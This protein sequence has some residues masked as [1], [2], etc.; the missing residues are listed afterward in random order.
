MKQCKICK[1]EKDFED[2][3][4]RKDSKD[5][6][7]NECK[8]CLKSQRKDY[9][10]NY[11]KENTEE[12]N[13]KIKDYYFKNPEKRKDKSKKWLDKNTSY[14]KKYQ[15]NRRKSDNLFKLMTNIR[16][17]IGQKIRNCGYDKKSKTNEILGCP[18]EDFKNYLESKFE[19]WMIWN[20][21]GK[22]NGDFNYGWDIDHII[23]ISSA[24]T[25]EEVIKLN[26]YTNLQPLCSKVNRDIKKDK[27]EYE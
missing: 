12:I 13:K 9:F 5:G 21:Y 1:E 24:T 11:R 16:T 2:F 17:L 25:E 20:N 15:Q 19:T 7:R 14:F 8:K 18:F 26:H 22:Y 3:S 27:I 6:F 4:S 23:P 10:D